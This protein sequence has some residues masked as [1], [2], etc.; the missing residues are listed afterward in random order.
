V[1]DVELCGFRD[2]LDVR[3]AGRERVVDPGG[4]FFD[5]W[6]ARGIVAPEDFDG[7]AVES[8]GGEIVAAEF[9]EGGGGAFGLPADGVGEGESY[10]GEGR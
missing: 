2:E 7:G 1:I 5:F 6:V 9:V 4:A 3:G 10:G 8:A